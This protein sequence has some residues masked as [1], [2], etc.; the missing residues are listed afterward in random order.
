M[1]KTIYMLIGPKGS[2]KTHVGTLINNNTNIKFLRVE[3][4]WLTVQPG[5]DGWKKVEQVIGQEFLIPADQFTG[6][7]VIV[8]CQRDIQQCIEL[9]G[10]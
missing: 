2:G 6:G 5:E 4:I 7:Y 8:D 9:E 1:N 10:G 3:S